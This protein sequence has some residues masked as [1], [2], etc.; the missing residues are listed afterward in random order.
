MVVLGGLTYLRDEV[1][2]GVGDFATFGTMLFGACS[3][4]ELAA[5]RTRRIAYRAA[6]GISVVAALFLVWLNLAVGIIGSE[7][8]PANWMYAG[9]LGI[10]V[11]GAVVSRGRPE[12]MAITLTVTALAQLAVGGIALV[13]RLGATSPSFPEAILFLSG[14]FALLWLVSASLFWRSAPAA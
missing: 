4:Y 3:V 10:A 9:V 13:A 2:W 7:D 12:G 14:F 1:A 6:V 8:N 11:G 5:R